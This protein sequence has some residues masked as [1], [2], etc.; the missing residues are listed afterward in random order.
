MGQ[1]RAEGEWRDE[2]AVDGH[3]LYPCIHGVSF[4]I[5]KDH[6]SAGERRLDPLADPVLRFKV[7]AYT[8]EMKTALPLAIPVSAD[9]AAR[10]EVGSL[11]HIR[12]A[13]R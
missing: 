13:A 11:L 7:H 6:R 12:R 3:R 10:F 2:R 8:C 9:V 5:C 1:A 4:L